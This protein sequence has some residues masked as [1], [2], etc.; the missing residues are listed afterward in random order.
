MAH[1]IKANKEHAVVNVR[2]AIQHTDPNDIADGLNETLRDQIGKNFISDYAFYNTDSPALV[3]ASDD[4]EEGELF[5]QIRT[6]AVCVQDSDYN[7]HWIKVETQLDLA[8]MSEDKLK[9]NIGDYIVFGEDDRVFVGCVESMQ[10][11]LI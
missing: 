9:D 7:E 3:K 8:A 6:Y 10:R 11:I 5:A 2:L 4:P 1:D